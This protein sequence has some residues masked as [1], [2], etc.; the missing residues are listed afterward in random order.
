MTAGGRVRLVSEGRSPVRGGHAFYWMQQ[1]QRASCNH[2]LE[3][4]VSRA[5]THS[6]PFFVL[7]CLD[8]GYPDAGKRHFG[9]MLDG[10]AGT[11]RDL[12]SRGIGLVLRMGDPVALFLETCRG[13]AFA[14]TD[15]GHSPVQKR[16]RIDAAIASP[17]PFFIVETDTLV[18]PSDLYPKR[19]WSAAVL[20]RRL[21]SMAEGYMDPPAPGKVLYEGF[22]PDFESLSPLDAASSLGLDL[23]AGSTGLP[24][25]GARA[26]GETLAA[27]IEDGL[28]SYPGKANDPAAD[29]VS[30]LSPYLHF[31]QISPLE[32]AGRI[33]E[34]GGPGAGDF[35]EQLL[36]RR[37][38]AVNFCEYTSAPDSWQAVPGWARDTLEQHSEDPREYVYTAGELE[39]ARTHDPAWN[40]AQ[41][42]LVEAGRMHGYM[43]M[44]WGKKILSWMESPEEA[45]HT[46]LDLNNRYALDGRDPNSFAGVGWC[47]GLHDR[48]WPPRPVYGSVRSMTTASL[49]ARFDIDSYIHRI[50][51]LKGGHPDGER[52]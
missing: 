10:L 16:W 46:A 31:G 17:C 32:V 43:R 14:V 23:T 7:F 8:K 5:E 40:A 27:F 35:M 48:P 4:A 13:A 11:A 3:F 21:D 2:A 25:A 1:A 41:T 24:K 47:F 45:F 30:G 33:R 9:F 38:L 15:G 18:P 36:V 52:S 29:C 6:L 34:A 26:A 49:R 42:E 12:A 19:A 51:T 39:G 44:Y 22:S 50:E 37:E 28:D 20:R